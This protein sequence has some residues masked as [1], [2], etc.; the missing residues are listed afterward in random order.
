M[1]ISYVPSIYILQK[2]PFADVLQNRCSSTQVFSCEYYK[3]FKNSFFKEQIW[4]LLLILCP[5][6]VLW[7]LNWLISYVHEIQ[8]TSYVQGVSFDRKSL[9]LFIFHKVYS[10]K[11]FWKL[12]QFLDVLILLRKPIHYWPVQN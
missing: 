9:K 11:K 7:T 2:Q 10:Y 1:W 6:N 8:I 3:I 5:L 12:W 4:W